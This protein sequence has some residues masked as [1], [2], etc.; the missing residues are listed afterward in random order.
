MVGRWFGVCSEVCYKTW[1]CGIVATLIIAGDID[2]PR[3]LYMLRNNIFREE[4]IA[5]EQ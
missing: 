5:E 3:Y 1:A 2:F 4:K